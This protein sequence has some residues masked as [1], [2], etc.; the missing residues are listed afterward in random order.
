M[1]YKNA[2][3][4]NLAEIA[5]SL[6]EITA[7]I[8]EGI[9]MTSLAET[10]SMFG[11]FFQNIPDDAKNTI[12]FGKVMELQKPNL[13]YEDVVWLVDDFGTCYTESNWKK[14]AE[15]EDT[16]F[17]LQRYIGIIV[18]ASSLNKREK[19]II[20]LT[21]M[22][23]LIYETLNISKSK[24]VNCPLKNEVEKVS[25]KNNKGMSVESL[26]KIYVL[27]VMYIVFANTSKYTD[28][29]D[30]RMPFRNNILHNGI[31]AYSD[32]DIDVAY[33]LMINLIEI[34]LVIKEQLNE[35]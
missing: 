13:K 8:V 16:K 30:K 34:L 9:D 14:I 12:F 19:L 4:D 32:E 31:V 26:G 5:A 27:A 17:A 11:K 28:A 35:E 10:L 29:I 23:P 2:F 22:E 15:N 21:H 25:I 1:A 6:L 3:E 24:G 20:L 33:D 18:S 7:R